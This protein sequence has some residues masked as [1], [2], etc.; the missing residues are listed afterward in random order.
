M[1]LVLSNDEVASILTME[2]CMEALEEGYQEQAEGRA[3]NQ[4][5][6]DINMPLPERA[7]R[8]ARYEFKTMVG[9]LPKA[10]VAALRMSSTLNHRPIRFGV[11]RFESLLLSCRTE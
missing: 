11:E 6:Y 9:I 8:Q 7:E 5:R 4:L 2:A 3:V 1:T 10:G